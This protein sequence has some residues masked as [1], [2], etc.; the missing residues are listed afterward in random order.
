[1][2]F[3]DPSAAREKGHAEVETD[4]RRARRV[5]VAGED[6]EVCGGGGLAFVAAG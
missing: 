6:E 2:L 1:M 3:R 5:V 4:G